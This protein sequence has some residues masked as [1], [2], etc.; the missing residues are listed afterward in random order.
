MSG[1]LASLADA[2][3][4]DPLLVGLLP[5]VPA[6]EETHAEVQGILLPPVLPRG[7]GVQL[8]QPVNKSFAL[9]SRRVH[10]AAGVQLDRPRRVRGCGRGRRSGSGVGAHTPRSTLFARFCHAVP[11]R[12]RRYVC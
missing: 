4:G 6:Y 7:L 9:T 10:A 12:R 8:L 1:L 2:V 11:W 3:L 5:R